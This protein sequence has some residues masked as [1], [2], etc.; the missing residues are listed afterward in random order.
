MYMYMYMYM[1]IKN[2]V[3]SMNVCCIYIDL[4]DIYNNLIEYMQCYS[5]NLA[6][7]LYITYKTMQTVSVYFVLDCVRGLI[8]SMWKAVSKT[9]HC[10]C[11]ISSKKYVFYILHEY[12]NW[13]Y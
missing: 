7:M 1:Y 10:K 5:A 8:Y 4:V 13:V 12:Y 2:M 3:M 9:F 11:M 6:N